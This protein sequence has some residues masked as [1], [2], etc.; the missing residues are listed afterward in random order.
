M[1]DVWFLEKICYPNLTWKARSNLLLSYVSILRNYAFPNWLDSRFASRRVFHIQPITMLSL[2]QKSPCSQNKS[3]FL[4]KHPRRF[5]SKLISIV[6]VHSFKRVMVALCCRQEEDDGCETWISKMNV[7]SLISCK[8]KRSRRNL[9]YVSLYCIITAFIGSDQSSWISV[10]GYKNMRMVFFTFQRLPPCWVIKL[11]QCV[12][13]HVYIIN[14]WK[15]SLFYDILCSINSRFRV[16][17]FPKNKPRQFGIVGTPRR[18]AAKEETDARGAIKIREET[19]KYSV[20]E[21]AVM[22]LFVSCQGIETRFYAINVMTGS[23]RRQSH[24]SSILHTTSWKR[25][26][27]TYPISMANA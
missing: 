15:I 27:N 18:L 1:A 4:I 25:T 16:G 9:I 23:E 3:K 26:V 6:A 22:A 24:S 17:A 13:N 2:A 8:T 10:Q 20:G 7:Q 11:A 21:Y 12:Q 14:W 5:S 19:C